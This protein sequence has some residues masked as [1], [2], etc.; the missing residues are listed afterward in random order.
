MRIFLH[1]L[2]MPFITNSMNLIND[3]SGP[4][5]TATN[6]SHYALR[7][8]FSRP[9]ALISSYLSYGH[10]MLT[11]T[12]PQFWYSWLV[13]FCTNWHFS[14]PFLI[15]VIPLICLLM[16]TTTITRGFGLHVPMKVTLRLDSVT[17]F[18]H[19]HISLPTETTCTSSCM[20]PYTDV[21]VGYRVS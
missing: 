8:Q 5:Q 2:I 16:S 20:K 1:T 13:D 3:Q 12:I 21:R 10:Y 7:I 9:Y 11:Q 6:N 4:T 17:L 15:K 19:L 14:I 18:P